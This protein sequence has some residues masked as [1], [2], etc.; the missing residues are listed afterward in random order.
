LQFEEGKIMDEKQKKQQQNSMIMSIVL[1]IIV[2]SFIATF[3][4][5][6]EGESA[7]VEYAFFGIV[8]AFMIFLIFSRG[9]STQK[10]EFPQK[11][12]ATS[13]KKAYRHCPKCGRVIAVD[14]NVCP[15]C[16]KNI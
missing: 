6:Y 9:A 14:V 11:I 7:H 5:M 2:F 15:Y 12:H 10:K 13:D 8:A 3:F 4:P 1:M 16:E